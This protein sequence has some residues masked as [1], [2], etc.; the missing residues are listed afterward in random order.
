[1][2]LEHFIAANR[3]Q[4]ITRCREKVAARPPG[5][6]AEAVSHHGVPVFL[7]QLL[8]ALRHG[9]ASHPD[10]ARSAVQHGQD[11]LEQGFSIGQVV[12]SYGDI[13]QTVT[14]LAVETDAAISAADFRTLNRCLDEAIAGAVTEYGRHRDQSVA[15]VANAR[16]NERLGFFAHELRN[17]LNTA[18]LAFEVLQTGNVGIKGSTG[19]VLHRSLVGLRALVTHSLAE[20]RL[21]QGIQQ[22]ESILV[23][24]LIGETGSAAALD[25]Q[26]RG[27]TLSV[28]PGEEGVTVAA[29]RQTLAA[30]LANLLQ[31]ACKFTQPNSSV[32]LRARASADRVLIEVEDECGGLPAGNADDLFRP[33]EQRSVDRTG[34][35]IGLSFSRWGVEAN[36]GRISVRNLPGQ[37]CV[38]TVDLPRRPQPA[39]TAA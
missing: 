26:S 23:A 15:N 11:L 4:I 24:D 3:E 27:L 1:M 36:D 10:I 38:F 37:G 39:V 14:E 17:Q 21:T 9:A 16:S 2:T 29:D 32:I 25:A 20:V 31:N 6:G 7:E 28:L 34:L 35:G 8:E 30:V 19:S 33:F 5:V 12:H 18:M 13:C 22:S